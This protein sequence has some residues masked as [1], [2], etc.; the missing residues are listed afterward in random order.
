M[1]LNYI[2]K[3]FPLIELSYDNIHHKKVPNIYLAIPYGKKYCLWFTHVNGEDV[4]YLLEYNIKNKKVINYKRS[5]SFFEKSLCYGTILYGTLVK[6]KK[7]SFF[8]CENIFYYEGKNICNK[9]FKLI[10]N[11]MVDMFKNKISQI[12]YTTFEL[13]ITMCIVNKDKNNLLTTINDEIYNIY[14][15]LNRNINNSYSFLTPLNNGNRQGTKTMIFRVMAD[16]KYNVYNLYCYNNNKIQFYQKTYIPDYKTSV[17][18]NNKFRIIKENINLDLLEESDD[19]EEFENT[20]EDKYVYL[21]RYYN[22]KCTFH[23]KTKR[24]IPI[25]ITHDKRIVNYSDLKI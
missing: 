12:A 15:I 6:N 19:E 7:S 21:D 18:L 23:Y 2:N 24:W 14:G 11:T 25:E 9:P 13:I 1:D 16:I 20:N 5:T 10:L 8:V 22:Y 3:N 4:L 17:M